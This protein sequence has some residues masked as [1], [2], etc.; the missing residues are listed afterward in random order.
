MTMPRR[1]GEVPTG[2]TISEV[3]MATRMSDRM[4]ELE[5]HVLALKR[6][7]KKKDNPR[8]AAMRAILAKS[9]GMNG[10]GIVILFDNREVKPLARY[11]E[12]TGMRLWNDLW[13]APEESIRNA[14]RKYIYKLRVKI[15]KETGTFRKGDNFSERS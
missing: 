6:A 11:T 7:R 14:V 5:L 15:L 4:Y 12:V 13:D 10:R 8:Q 9:P 3:A 2:H 1:R